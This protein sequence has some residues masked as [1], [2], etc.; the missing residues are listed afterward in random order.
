MH[1]KRIKAKPTNLTNE[2]QDLI[3]KVLKKYITKEIYLNGY[4]A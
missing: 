4:K 3:D 2:P 1:K